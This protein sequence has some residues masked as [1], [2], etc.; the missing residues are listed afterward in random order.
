MCHETTRLIKISGRFCYHFILQGT[1]VRLCSGL[2]QKLLAMCI[3][4]WFLYIFCLRRYLAIQL[5]LELSLLELVS[6][7]FESFISSSR[8]IYLGRIKFMILDWCSLSFSIGFIFYFF[9]RKL[10]KLFLNKSVLSFYSTLVSWNLYFLEIAVI[11]RSMDCFLLCILESVSLSNASIGTRA[12]T[13]HSSGWFSCCSFF[14]W[15]L[16]WSDASCTFL[17]P[18]HVDL[19]R[20]CTLYAEVFIWFSECN[21]T[22]AAKL[23]KKS[24]FSGGLCWVLFTLLCNNVH[25]SQFILL[26]DRKFSRHCSCVN[27]GHWLC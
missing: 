2:E 18:S 20:I 7:W 5:D 9:L 11:T 17:P 13:L 19:D 15:N 3:G 23:L 14:Q 24:Y 8:C 21:S 27:C 6:C 25:I 22:E 12:C 1:C 10:V 26:T 4:V 16:W